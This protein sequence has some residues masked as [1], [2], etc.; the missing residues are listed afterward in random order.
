MGPKRYVELMKRPGSVASIPKQ[1]L[2]RSGGVGKDGGENFGV[3]FFID[4]LQMKNMATSP[5]NNTNNT[6][7]VEIS[8]DITEPM[9]ITL[10]ERLKTKQRILLKKVKIILVRHIYWR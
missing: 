10:I 8:F 4:N 3:D 5:N 9:G 2:M 7:A 6:N 1:L